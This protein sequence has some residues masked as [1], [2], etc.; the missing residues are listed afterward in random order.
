MISY[1]AVGV[2]FVSLESTLMIGQVGLGEAG[3]IRAQHLTLFNI[4][5]HFTKTMKLYPMLYQ[6]HFDNSW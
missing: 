6:N 4:L 5:C 3:G 1:Y 2:A